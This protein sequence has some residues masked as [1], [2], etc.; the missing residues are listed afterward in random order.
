[1]N[2]R[3][4]CAQDREL[5]DRVHR[6]GGS[7]FRDGWARA[8][9]Q[10]YGSLLTHAAGRLLGQRVGVGEPIDLRVLEIGFGIGRGLHNLIDYLGIQQEGVVG[11]ELFED[12]VNEAS[13]RW[14]RA[15]FETIGPEAKDAVAW[16]YRERQAGAAIRT[17]ASPAE[18][19]G[20]QE[21]G[22][23]A[24]LGAC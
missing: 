22:C 8:E 16:L 17:P 21:C 12:H 24:P 7:F 10:S 20:F 4:I 11:I 18:R 2:L 3:E 14:P 5:W 13:R 23:G 15:R 1:M 6:A 9:W 19:A